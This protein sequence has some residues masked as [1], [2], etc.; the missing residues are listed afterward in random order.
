MQF[1][2]PENR[3]K[4]RIL[5]IEDE[6]L[7]REFVCDFLEDIGFKTLQASNGKMGIDI[8]RKENPDL[9]LTDLRMPEMNGLDVLS[10]LQKDFPDK[11]VIVIS[12]TGSLNDV[13]QS[14]KFG[15]WDYILKP[16]HDYSV[17]EMAVTR[18]LER[19]YLLNENKKYKEHLEEEVINRTDELV[20]STQRFKT[21]F[22]SAGDAIFIHDLQGKL[23]DVN[24]QAVCYLGYSR[25]QLLQMN[26]SDLF[27]ESEVEHFFQYLRTF[28][29]Q[30]RVIYESLHKHHSGLS[31][32]VEVNACTITMDSSPQILA[33]CRDIT[34]RKRAE[35]ERN[36]L[37]KQMITAQKMESIGLLASGIAHDF[38]NIL[39]A[40]NGYTTLFGYQVQPG[41]KESEYLSKITEIISMGQSITKRVT[42]FVRKDKDELVDI[43]IHKILS[44]SETLLRPNC[45]NITISLDLKAE[46]SHI[47][48]DEGQLQNAF[49]NLGINARDAM[50]SG[51]KLI[52]ATSNIRDESIDM[53]RIAVTDTGTG[54]TKEIL[55]KIY[56]PLFTTKERGKG[57]GL[58]LTSVLY[59]IK[60]LHGKID[61]QSIP[62]QGTTFIILIPI[63]NQNT[64]I[65]ETKKRLHKKIQIISAENS[66]SND[67]SSKFSSYEIASQVHH[68][69]KSAIDWIIP[70]KSS[71]S[72]FLLDYNLPFSNETDSISALRKSSPEIPI[73]IF[74]SKDNV[75]LRKLDPTGLDN[76]F[77]IV[78]LNS[79][80]FY[81][82]INLLCNITG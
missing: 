51:G 52:F 15:A 66:I 80:R 35:E 55:S 7:I 69:L 13:V 16:I 40:L 11:P 6:V 4:I 61:V 62:G 25:E 68:D 48:G 71:I 78:P 82:S 57:T 22:E 79:D 41:T 14:L 53:L 24:Q 23:I 65:P 27:I 60:N 43:D 28:P 72:L 34:E 30:S 17:L 20:K 10:A 39:S 50:P 29:L 56:D 38:N 44:D 81:E 59:C 32:P 19:K 8:C 64:V 37:E 2:I 54:M 46:N 49:L 33:I 76:T 63:I 47:L 18:V 5:A 58:G 45:K 3:S 12:G 73:I 77:Q 1:D 67:L 42:T 9:I 75:A 70:N 21:L 36:K 74:S 26:M 31:I